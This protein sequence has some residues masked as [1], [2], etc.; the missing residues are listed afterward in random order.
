[1]MKKLVVILDNGH[2]NT[3]PGKCSPDK[4]LYEWEWTREIAARIYEEL[5]LAGIES[6]LLVPEDKDIALDR[7]K[8]NRVKRANNII[9]EAKDADK[10]CILL[11]IHINA[12]GGDGKWKNARGWSGWI[13]NSASDKSKKLAQLLYS[14]CE[15]RNLQG[16]RSVPNEKYWEANFAITRETNCPAVLTENLFQDNKE[17]V[18]YLMTEEGKQNIIDLHIEAVKKYIDFYTNNEC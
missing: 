17:D 9:K 13:A 4:Q 2:G 1:M 6:V 11:S 14:E 12:A 18:E 5:L 3:T 15:I 10:E 8:D 7:G 16:N